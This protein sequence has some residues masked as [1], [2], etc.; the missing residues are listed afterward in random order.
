LV[1]ASPGLT[2]AT[3]DITVY[4]GP[5]IVRIIR[6]RFAT[7]AGVATT[8]TAGIILVKDGATVKE[9]AAAAKTPGSTIYDGLDGVQ[10]R[11]SVVVNFANG[12]DNP[13]SSGKGEVL[14]RPLDVEVNW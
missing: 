12:L 4:N 11:T 1:N 2:T 13:A 8:N 5:A 3:G 14:Y 10:F 7:D 6:V 9:G